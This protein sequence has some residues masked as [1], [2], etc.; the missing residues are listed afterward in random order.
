MMFERQPRETTT[1]YPYVQSLSVKMKAVKLF[2]LLPYLSVAKFEAKTYSH[3][4][5]H[6]NRKIESDGGGGSKRE[7]E[8]L[9]N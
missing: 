5:I 3:T 2:P 1:S 6:G 9:I 7:R 4:C 8:L